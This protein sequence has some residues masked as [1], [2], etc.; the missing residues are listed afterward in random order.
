MS[1]G[2]LGRKVGMTRYFTEDG[3]NVPVTVIQ[4]GPCVVTEVKTKDK[5]GYSAVQ[6]G[7][8]EVP[9]E[10]ATMP[11]IGHDAKAGVSARRF[12]QEIRLDEDSERELG[13]EITVADFED[14]MFVDVV[15]T[16][17]GK[18]FQGVMKRHN[19]AGLEA[20]HGVERKHRSPGSIGGGGTNL[21]TGPK[22][23]KGKRMAG[24][25]GAVRTTV[26]NLDV[27]KIIPE[28]NLL[29]LKGTVP[30]PNKGLVF[31]RSARRIG[32]KK[33]LKVSAAQK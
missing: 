19:F 11:L 21:G 8:E 13:S 2:I 4:A 12:H 25:M 6:I 14:D 28:Q 1:L 15:A 32:R 26:R 3:V 22:L 16:S 30:G 5:H 31:V 20:S 33:Q 27:V 23:K 18:G 7:F 24:Q 17:K 10:R 29:L 9:A